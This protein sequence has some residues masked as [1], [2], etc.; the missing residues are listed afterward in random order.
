MENFE[1][2]LEIL[3]SKEEWSDEE[4]ALFLKL[5]EEMGPAALQPFFQGEFLS[6]LSQ[7]Q[8]H[9][10]AH[11]QS[12]LRNIHKAA[13]LADPS[14]KLVQMPSRKTWRPWLAAASVL[15]LLT[16]AVY[17]LVLRPG[18]DGGSQPVAGKKPEDITAPAGNRATITLASGE[19]LYLDSMTAGTLALQG[20]TQVSKLENG[21]IQY[22]SEGESNSRAP[23]INTLINPKGSRVI[24]VRLADGTRVWLNA[25]ASI[26]Y[27]A[28][29][30]GTS[31]K[32]KL[33]GEAYFEVAKDASRQFS[34]QSGN[35]ITQVLGTS[36]NMNAN[37]PTEKTSVTL[38]EGKVMVGNA[39]E[40]TG[41]LIK[42][43]Q[44]ALVNTGGNSAGT[45]QVRDGVDLSGVLAWKNGIFY[46]KDK[47]LEEVMPEIARW[48]DIEVEYPAGIPQ[49]KLFGK[50]GRDLSLMQLLQ[51]LNEMDVKC[52]LD[53]RT[54]I[55]LK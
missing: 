50:L 8:P 35:A 5:L 28:S 47:S 24:D 33:K 25:G 48:Y 40:N 18:N 39:N 6:N 12:L 41:T 3:F 51:S 20:N 34:V 17:W 10:L 15:V 49:T 9:D 30:T 42:P 7:T 14:A 36:F 13:G 54:I 21:S 1:T 44:Q 45:V 26:E 46:L 43:G 11:A 23:S 53:G 16:F 32:I 2:Q 37:D 31:R 38:L 29:F 55:I 19:V 4:H 52:R 22:Q 27:P